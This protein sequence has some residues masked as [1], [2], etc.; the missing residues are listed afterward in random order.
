MAKKRGVAALKKAYSMP[1][2]EKIGIV[3]KNFIVFIV[4]FIVSFILYSLS[5]AGFWNDL[6]FLLVLVFGFLSLALLIVWMILKLMKKGK[7]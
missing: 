3:V 7:E 6:F 5:S 2:S 4:L 1:L